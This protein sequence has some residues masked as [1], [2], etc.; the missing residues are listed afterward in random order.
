MYEKL[1]QFTWT[2]GFLAAGLGLLTVGLGA[3]LNNRLN[4]SKLEVYRGR[5]TPTVA[6]SQVN[7]MVKFEIAGEVLKPGV[8]QLPRGSRI[9]EAMMV[10]GGMALHADREWVEKNINRAAM[11]GDGAK[12]YI[13]KRNMIYDLGNTNKTKDK[14][15]ENTEEVMGVVDS[16][17]IN[18]NTAGVDDLDKLSGVGPAIAKKIID[19]REKNGGFRDIN[20]I[21]LVSGIGDK[22][23]EKIKDFITL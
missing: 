16:G 3:N 23:Y 10:A 18:I 1:R 6:I 7:P 8:Y 13:P 21:K 9:D 15:V 12:I 14:K 20:E 17:L 5:L 2:D 19:Y 11:I 22:M 4:E